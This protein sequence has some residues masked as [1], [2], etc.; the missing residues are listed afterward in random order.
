VNDIQT[1]QSDLINCFSRAMSVEDAKA[2]F[3]QLITRLSAGK[4]NPRI[5]VK[6]VK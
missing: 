1:I 2:A 4:A 5:I 3:N 6:L